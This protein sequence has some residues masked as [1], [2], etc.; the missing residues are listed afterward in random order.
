MTELKKSEN[1]KF[2]FELPKESERES[3]ANFSSK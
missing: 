1:H 3:Y 2:I